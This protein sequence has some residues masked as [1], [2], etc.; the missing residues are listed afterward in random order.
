MQVQNKQH[1]TVKNIPQ[2][3]ANQ[4]SI[5]AVC[6]CF[7]FSITPHF[8]HLP[9]WVS[10]FVIVALGWR[11]LQNLGMIKALSKWI[12]VPLVLFGGVGVFAEYWAIVGRDAGLAFL[13]VMMSL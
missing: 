12:V 1:L 5:F 2:E 6:V 8:F 4:A 7:L 13:T 11:T 9:L 10:G 3:V